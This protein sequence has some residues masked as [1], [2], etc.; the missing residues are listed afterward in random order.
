MN[1]YEVIT[2]TKTYW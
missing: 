2:L 1:T